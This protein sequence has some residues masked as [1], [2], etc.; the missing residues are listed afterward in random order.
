VSFTA[1]VFALTVIFLACIFTIPVDP[2]G[3][4][5]TRLTARAQEHSEMNSTSGTINITN[6]VIEPNYIEDP[7]TTFAVLPR[8]VAAKVGDTFTV[9]ISVTNVTNMYSWQ[10]HLFFDNK[11]LRCTSVSLLHD[12]VFS[13]AYTVGDA[14]K[15]YNSNSGVVLWIGNDRGQVLMGDSLLGTDQPNFSGSGSLCQIEFTAISSGSSKLALFYRD[16]VETYYIDNRVV[17]IRPMVSN[18]EVIVA[19]ID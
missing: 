19:S 15:D 9:R 13:Y 4:P 18:G 1:A 11:I 17:P 7:F 5:S 16:E 6:L 2:N 8:E 3:V 14:L 12:Y 10:V